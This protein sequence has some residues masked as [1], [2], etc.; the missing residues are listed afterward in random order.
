MRSRRSFPLLV[1]L[2]R[3]LL[4][5]LLVSQVILP[6]IAAFAQ[7]GHVLVHETAA[8]SER[9]DVVMLPRVPLV[10][11]DVLL[12]HENREGAAADD[13]RGRA[14]AP[15]LAGTLVHR[16]ASFQVARGP[17]VLLLGGVA[18]QQVNGILLCISLNYYRFLFGDLI[19]RRPVP[20]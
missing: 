15:M 7:N 20:N 1:E 4:D 10:L 8:V 19:P 6:R 11:G 14:A 17:D 9:R 18:I 12:K 2:A 5:F 13:L 3:P 16:D